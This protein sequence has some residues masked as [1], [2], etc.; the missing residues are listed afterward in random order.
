M[1]AH[2]KTL[3]LVKRLAKQRP[4]VRSLCVNQRDT[5]LIPS[6]CRDKTSCELN[7]L[8][9]QNNYL[10]AFFSFFAAFFSLG[11][12][13][14]SFLVCFL[15]SIPF[16]MGALRLS[17]YALSRGAI[18]MPYEASGK[19]VDRALQSRTSRSNAKKL[20]KLG[21]RS[22]RS[23]QLSSSKSANNTPGSPAVSKAL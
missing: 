20:A 14:G 5:Y 2:C 15:L 9:R 11:V 21:Q 10:P 4:R 6:F 16:D 12:L 8:P 19:W 13:D 17:E 7:V 22:A 1:D 18:V 3:R 23:R